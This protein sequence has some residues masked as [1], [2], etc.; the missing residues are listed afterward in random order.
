MYSKIAPISISLLCVV[1]RTSYSTAMQG[2]CVTKPEMDNSQRNKHDLKP[3]EHVT[4]HWHLNKQTQNGRAQP[5]HHSM[6]P[7][8]V[9]CSINK[10]IVEWPTVNWRWRTVKSAMTYR[11][12]VKSSNTSDAS[13]SFRFVQSIFVSVHSTGTGKEHTW[14]VTLM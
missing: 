9:D 3:S 11:T 10:N 8:M 4:Q 1:A 7:L 13:L 6:Y 2:L 5:I 14:H 12:T